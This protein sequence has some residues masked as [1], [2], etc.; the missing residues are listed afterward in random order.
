M[1]KNKA[2]QGSL[3]TNPYYFRHFDLS[4]FTHLYNGNPFPSGGLPIDMGDEKTLV[5]AYNTLIEGSGIRQSK[6]GLQV[7]HRMFITGHFMLLFDL[8]PDLTASEGHI[9]LPDQGN[10]RMELQFD[11]PLPEALTCLL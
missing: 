11:N 7:I 10:V 6:V 3:D 4:H 2:F 1:I 9:S 5:L 8:T